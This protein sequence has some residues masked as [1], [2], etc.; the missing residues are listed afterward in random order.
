MIFSVFCFWTFSLIPKKAYH[1]EIFDGSILA[2]SVVPTGCSIQLFH[3][4]I[5]V[6][7]IFPELLRARKN[8]DNFSSFSG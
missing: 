5:K 1:S 8:Q 7:P 6:I 2:F 3:D 4:K